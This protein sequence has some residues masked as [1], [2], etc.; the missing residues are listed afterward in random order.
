MWW[1]TGTQDTGS[2]HHTH[3]HALTY[4]RAIK[5]PLLDMQADVNFPDFPGSCFLTRLFD[6]TEDKCSVPVQ[7][8]RSRT[9]RFNTMIRLLVADYDAV[10]QCYL[11]YLFLT[12]DNFW[13]YDCTWRLLCAMEC[14]NV[15][16]EIN[17]FLFKKLY[18]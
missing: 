14:Y 10:Y 9:G 2:A 1:W 12:S 11:K 6:I 5:Q 7:P 3:A 16:M 8:T 15:Q 17:V 13:K 18:T 4:S